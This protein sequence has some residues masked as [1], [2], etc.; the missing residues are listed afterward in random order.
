[1][2][3]QIEAVNE[4]GFVQ[5]IVCLGMRGV[6]SGELLVVL[7]RHPV[8]LLFPILRRIPVQFFFIG[9]LAPGPQ[10]AQKKNIGYI[11]IDYK[12]DIITQ[13]SDKLFE[14]KIQSLIVEGGKQLLETFIDNNLWDEARVL[15]GNKTFKKG[16][17]APEINALPT[18]TEVI[19]EDKIL[20]FKNF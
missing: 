5:A 12:K 19:G 1:V 2:F 10:K 15:I 16:L 8:H 20:I 4:P 13:I 11:T 18:S 7:G 17:K 9:M 3:L 14:R 6:R